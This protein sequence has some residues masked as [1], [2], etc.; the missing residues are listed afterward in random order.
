MLKVEKGF[1]SAGEDLNSIAKRF[2]QNQDLLKLLY[3][4]SADPLSQPPLSG[5]ALEEAYN[6]CVRM[7]P[8]MVFDENKHSSLFL[9]MDAFRPSANTAYRT[10]RIVIDVLVPLESWVFA[11]GTLRPFKIM[12]KIEEELTDEP[13]NGIGRLEFLGADMVMIGQE[14]AGYTM[15]FETVNGR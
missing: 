1:S 2:L 9:T 8:K 13:L 6:K 3:Y 7:V 14:L 11:D 4:A 10:N 12:E 15:I 5:A